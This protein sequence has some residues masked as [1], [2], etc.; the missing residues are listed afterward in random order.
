MKRETLALALPLDAQGRRPPVPPVSIRSASRQGDAVLACAVG[1]DLT[2]VA[3]FV[4]SLRTVFSGQVILLVDRKPMLPAWLSTHGVETVVI[5]NDRRPWRPRPAASQFVAFARIL[6][7]RR[8]IRSVILADVREVVFQS[9][10]F[11]RAPADLHF[12]SGFAGPALDPRAAE[13]IVGGPLA[14]QLS[15]RPPIHA[16]VVAGSRAGVERFCRAFLLLCDT[17]RH[18]AM[19]GMDQT[20]CQLVAHLGLAGGQVRPDFERVAT[21]S[22]RMT[23]ADGRF[24]NPDRSLS[25]IILGYRH[26]PTLADYI[27][28][29]WGLSTKRLPS[30]TALTRTRAFLQRLA[31]G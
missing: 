5:A 31:G 21:A 30:G 28:H 18:G 12:Y 20:A 26:S 29:R 14:R 10:P 23:V 22:E 9:D 2:E 27:D 4:R 3:P 11:H 1:C 25:P 15:E 19:S 24:W 13:A 7:Q 17:A 8:D 6:Q 16:G